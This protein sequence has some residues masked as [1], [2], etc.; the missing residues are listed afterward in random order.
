M[1]QDPSLPPTYSH[2]AQSSTSSSSH[3]AAP[4]EWYEAPTQQFHYSSIQPTSNRIS[5]S[6]SPDVLSNLITSLAA[7]SNSSSQH[8]EWRT[9]AYIS[10]HSAA[11]M[12]G[13]DMLALS[14]QI[15]PN[16]RSESQY[17][18]QYPHR[19]GGISKGY[20]NQEGSNISP[21]VYT[22]VAS[23]QRGHTE[24]NKSEM[25]RFGH[26][27]SASTVA[28][29]QPS[30][31]PRSS[32]PP[33]SIINRITVSTM[34]TAQKTEQNIPSETPSP[35]I[36]RDEIPSGQDRDDTPESKENVRPG[37]GLR[38]FSLLQ[39][40]TQ[41]SPVFNGAS[42]DS[43][44]TSSPGLENHLIPSRRSSIRRSVV[45]PT[46]DRD[47]KRAS[48]SSQDLR[49]LQID[50]GLIA[51]DHSTVR[52]I[53]ELQDAKEKR[54]SEWRRDGRK[55][56]RPKRNSM[57]SPT[58]VHKHASRHSTQSVVGIVMEVPEKERKAAGDTPVPNTDSGALKPRPTKSTLPSRT[59]SIL[60]TQSASLTAFRER[61]QANTL[62]QHRRGLSSTLRRSITTNAIPSDVANLTQSAVEDE[63]ETFLRSPTL[64][65]RIKHPRTG[66]VIAFS[67]VGD[68][69]GFPVICCVGMGLTRYVTV[70]YDEL[71]R[72]LKLRL[73]TPDRP[74]VGESEPCNDGKS[75][76]L[77]W[78]DDVYVLCSSLEIEA[79]SLLAHSAGAIY[80]LAVALRL[81]N[82][83]RG[84]L[85]LLAP[86]IPPS[87]M[88]TMSNPV[89]KLNTRGR[90]ATEP[91]VVI[92][93]TYFVFEDC[94][95]KFHV[96]YICQHKS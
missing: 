8:F 43:P 13:E 17:G 2:A 1:N 36:T 77:N 55:S 3:N 40:K 66:R 95:C 93:S 15:E 59:S 25:R 32:L 63:V 7:I 18:S 71:A 80:A 56:D 68:P 9:N 47:S 60:S 86:W 53:K 28:A 65:Q 61:R 91:E 37:N 20:A 67:E 45:D 26:D 85:H 84:R 82:H 62:P 27:K 74:G 49:D 51:E 92:C 23:S 5:A 78:A 81:P 39:L 94:K 76:P 14:P 70:F 24:P 11:A 69:K 10:K 46:R 57:P 48:V 12:S 35:D 96:C 87:Q 42:P 72:S 6:V 16:L 54:Q 41:T 83:V 73:I 22:N 31:S 88:T 19:S 38:P 90:D 58:S 52:R 4:V 50:E 75:A 44:A 89:G 21:A 33:S 30:S 64:T 29:N 34:G 79:F